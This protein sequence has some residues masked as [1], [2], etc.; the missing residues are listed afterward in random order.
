MKRF[1]F[2]KRS[3]PA[4]DS[5]PKPVSGPAAGRGFGDSSTFLTGEARTD[6]RSLQILLDTIAA[7]SAN[8]DLETVL[9]QIV[10]R[11]IQV[12]QAERAL[13]LI[14]DNGD[15][16]DVRVAQDKEGKRLPSEQQWS[17]T[18]VRRCLADRQAVR[19][20]VNSDREALEL[21]Q[22]VYDLKLRAVMCAPLVANQRVL[23]VIY[24]D[25]RAAR[26]EFSDRDLALFSAIS[27]QLAVSL[28]NARLHADSLE[29]VRLQKDIEI[30]QRI[31]QHLMPQVPHGLPGVDLA[32]RYFGA[33]ESSGDSYDFVPMPGGKLAVM[34]GDVTGHG[35]GAALLGHAVQAALR[36]YL[37][38]IDDLS[39]VV[40]RLNHRLSS[41]VEAGNFMSLLVALVD[42]KAL[43]LQY[44][45]GG[46][47]SLIHCRGDRVTALDKTGMV[48]GVV[49][50]QDYAVSES[51]A[52]QKGDLLFFHSDGVDEAMSS[53]RETFGEARLHELLRSLAG[54]SAEETL[55]AV[56]A[57]LRQHAGGAFEDDLTMVAVRIV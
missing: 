4:A 29:K 20:V 27:A 53:R 35:I 22:S 47:P 19:S 30:A 10:D 44:V 18:L 49:A 39:D 38:L 12:T 37:E 8:I 15:G 31:Q 46:H 56:E 5:K 42:P 9:A 40:T 25:S 51:V 52:L 41:S 57:A 11:S 48:L 43:S 26:R 45:N 1:L 50:D 55:A 3:E 33:S 54:R 17:R 24:V 28:E 34:V 6:Q 13:L 2:W 16:L 23:G 21:G 36:S 7:V 14:G 32:L